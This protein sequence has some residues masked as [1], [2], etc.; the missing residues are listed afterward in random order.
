[1]PILSAQRFLASSNSINQINTVG[2]PQYEIMR[3]VLSDIKRLPTRPRYFIPSV[4]R[5]TG[6]TSSS[7]SINQINTVGTP[8]YEIMRFVLSDT[9]RVATRPR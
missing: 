2:T 1:M 3:F 4:G 6:Y 8:Q 5:R 9:K 7:N